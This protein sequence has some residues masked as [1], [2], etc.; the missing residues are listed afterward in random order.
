MVPG[1]R[2]QFHRCRGAAPATA[3]RGSL[4]F[5][6]SVNTLWAIREVGYSAANAGLI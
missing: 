1:A 5:V 6:S 4:V 2:Q 3:R